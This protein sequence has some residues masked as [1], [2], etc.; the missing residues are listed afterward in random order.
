M[1]ERM[2]DPHDAQDNKAP[3]IYE[4]THPRLNY[5]TRLSVLTIDSPSLSLQCR[6]LPNRTDQNRTD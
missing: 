3:L 2:S 6:H 1:I 5:P 4:H